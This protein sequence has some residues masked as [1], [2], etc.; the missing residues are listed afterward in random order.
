[1]GC[2]SFPGVTLHLFTANDIKANNGENLYLYV[3]Y[4]RQS[5]GKNR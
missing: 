4:H 3:D 5:A 2:V 1:M